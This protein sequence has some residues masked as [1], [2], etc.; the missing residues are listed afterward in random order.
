MNWWKPRV[1]ACSSKAN[2]SRVGVRRGSRPPRSRCATIVA[3]D[4]SHS[5]WWLDQGVAH[6]ARPVVVLHGG[7][8]VDAAAV[9]DLLP[10]QPRVE[11]RADPGLAARGGERRPDHRVDEPAA[12]VLERLQLELLLG[13]EVGEQP[14]LAHLGALG[15][16][17]DGEALE[18]DL[19]GDLQRLVEDRGLGVLALA[20]VVKLA[21][22][23]VFVRGVV[24]GLSGP[25]APA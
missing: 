10:A 11:Q 23:F 24:C 13:A 2:W 20:H 6:G 22:P 21:R 12:G 7:G 16:L 17:A 5:C 19:R 18:P 15:E 25:P 4:S 1:S 9:E 8:D 14:A 3:I